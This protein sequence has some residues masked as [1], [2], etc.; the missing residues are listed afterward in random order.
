MSQIT[1]Y[2][3]VFGDYTEQQVLKFADEKILDNNFPAVCRFHKGVNAE[4]RK[5]V[6]YILSA[7][8]WK[9]KWIDNFKTLQIDE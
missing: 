4:V 5:N 8:G 2:S 6:I 3:D 1:R 7:A 9:A